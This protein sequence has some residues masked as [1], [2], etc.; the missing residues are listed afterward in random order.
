MSDN[1][2][3]FHGATRLDLSPD[4][5]LQEAIGEVET[6]VVLGWDKDGTEYFASSVAD[7]GTVVWLLERCKK[8]LFEKADDISNGVA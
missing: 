5:V 4:Q 6:V 7:G 3:K 1:V 8:M 2:V